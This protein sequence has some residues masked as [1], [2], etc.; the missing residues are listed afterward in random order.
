[1]LRGQE[2]VKNRD[3]IIKALTQ[4]LA[5]EGLAAYRYL[6]LAHWMTGPAAHE[7]TELFTKMSADEW[8]HLDK[9]LQ[10][11]IQLDGTPLMAPSDWEKHSFDKY[12]A[13]PKDPA[14]IKPVLKD[15]LESERAAISFYAELAEKTQHEDFVTFQ[16]VSELLAHEVE[17]EQELHKFLP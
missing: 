12:S 14:E 16:L 6:Y 8:G 7:A 1:M 11:I 15:S 13:P 5:A 3:E 17:D 4:A 2:I 9:L 10:R